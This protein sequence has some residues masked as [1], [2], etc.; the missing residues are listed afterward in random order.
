VLCG[1]REFIAE[2][3][4]YRKMLGGG[5][6]QAGVL[7]AAGIYALE[8]MVARLAEDHANAQ[9]AAAG[10]AELPGV[11]LAPAP[12]T[13]LIFFTVAGWELG[14][15]VSRL[16]EAGVRCFDEG[17]RIRWVTHYGIERRD[18]EE[19]LVRLRSVLATGA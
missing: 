16:E 9:V 7:A 17:G 3:R 10:L 6:R 5:M 15:L 2:A 4:R 13:N 14:N 19:A 11:E 8:N 18:I 12:Q 1:S